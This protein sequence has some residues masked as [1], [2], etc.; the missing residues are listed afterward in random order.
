M[1]PRR[2]RIGVLAS[3]PIQYQAPIFRELARE[4]DIHVYFAHRQDAQGQADAGFGVAFDWDVDLLDGYSHEFLAN[5]ARR[6]GTS[7]FPG[8]DT[9]GVGASIASLRPDAFLVMGW[10]LKA[11][12]QAAFACRR[13]AV[14]VMV[15]GDSILATRRGI[16]K[17]A[18]KRLG[19]PWLLRRFDACLYVGESSRRYFSHY[20]V[21]EGRLFFS[22]H[23][24]DNAAFARAAAAVDR[25][26][27]RRELGLD[28]PGPVVL[29]A[30][31]FVET[32]H[33]A[34]LVAA[35]GDLRRRGIAAR[36]LFIGDGPLRAHLQAHATDCGAP[37]VFGGFWNQARMPAAYA[38]ADA[39]ALPSGDSETWG[40]VVNEALACGLPVVVSD[41]VGCGPDLVVPGVSGATFP[42]G[43][44]AALAT[45]LAG[46][47]QER[48][49]T[50]AVEAL[51]SRY[52]P[53]RAA[54]GILAASDA[55][56]SRSERGGNGG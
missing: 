8:C 17:R 26:A 29:F 14:P 48:A 54:S 20:G 31:R 46:V 27:L 39:L 40:L 43:D 9:P 25:A 10:N 13:N 23:C 16:A 52:S 15:R 5:V 33:A 24:I 49:K 37:I 28:G 2:L 55:I 51:I 45:A 3:H 18:L 1:T 30:G 38:V 36:G 34:D 50:D 4:A 21:E 56:V 41:A 35:L 47:L 11:Y 19:Y 32:K 6:P 22:P 12:W 7:E 42:V 53:A 44:P